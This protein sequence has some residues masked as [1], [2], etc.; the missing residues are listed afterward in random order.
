MSKP[1]AAVSALVVRDNKVLL[2][3]R[4]KEP[5]SGFWSLPGGAVE[6]GE[7]VRE[8]LVREV[9]EE[10]SVEVEPAE[11]LDVTDVIRR[12]KSSIPVHYV[13]VTFKAFYL[14]GFPAPSSDVS[15]TGWFT[16]S[17]ARSM[18]L[19]DGL[20]AVLERVLND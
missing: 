2:V 5:Y 18:Q 11:V 12:D 13:V 14:D 17:E 3:R 9:R 16:L 15:E 1:I 19:T 4:S 8:A 6:L 20:C 7:T 10:T